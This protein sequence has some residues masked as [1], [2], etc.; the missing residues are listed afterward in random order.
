MGLVVVGGDLFQRQ[1]NNKEDQSDAPLFNPIMSFHNNIVW[2]LLLPAK[3]VECG[4]GYNWGS[5]GISH[6]HIHVSDWPTLVR[7]PY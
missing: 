5:S 1:G 7:E 3:V 2:M 6:I 4:Y